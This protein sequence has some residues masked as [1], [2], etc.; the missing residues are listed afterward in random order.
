[1]NKYN[2][3]LIGLGAIGA[4]KDDKYDSPIS[5][6]VLTH[7]N[8]IKRN[9]RL[10]LVGAIDKDK[11]KRKKTFDKWEVP[12]YE[13]LNS[14]FIPFCNTN[15]KIDIVIIATP[16]E[17]H[18]KVIKEVVEKINPRLIIL[19]KPGCINLDEIKELKQYGNIAINYT[20]RYN[21]F[22][23]SIQEL[24]QTKTI[25]FM[26]VKYCRGLFRDACHAIDLLTWFCGDF[27]EGKL[28]GK[29]IADHFENDLTY[30][31]WLSFEKCDSCFLFAFDGRIGDIF[32]VEIGTSIGIFRL[33][34][35]SNILRIRK[36]EEEKIYGLYNTISE[37]ET[38]QET[39]LTTAL[40]ELYDNAVGYFDE[41]RGL[42]C[43]IDDAIKVHEI[44]EYLKKG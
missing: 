16:T 43:A 40:P 18:L 30:S 37:K 11:D 22:I 24:L 1:M 13:N 6:N 36:I 4:L 31:A 26:N 7:A 8:A 32:E 38:I 17:T 5:T 34:D 21:L 44:L 23:Q 25:Y 10:N 12:V 28:I 39:Y 33:T 35:H 29:G 27:K 19:E 41:G 42:I 3:V 15:E 20:R 14:F 9:N 2:C